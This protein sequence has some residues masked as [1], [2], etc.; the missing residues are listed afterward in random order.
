MGRSCSLIGRWGQVQSTF[1]IPSPLPTKQRFQ[2]RT[3]HTTTGVD[4]HEG[5]MAECACWD[6]AA[7]ACST[8]RVDFTWNMRVWDTDRGPEH[9][10]PRGEYAH[11]SG[12]APGISDTDPIRAPRVSAT[13]NPTI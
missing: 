2:N 1:P 12:A 4:I 7:I 8:A 6:G 10:A 13:D 9:P 3:Q 5:H 11:I